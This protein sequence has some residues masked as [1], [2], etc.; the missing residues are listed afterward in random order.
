MTANDRM[1]DQLRNL[2]GQKAK[3][4]CIRLWFEL[5]LAGRDIWSDHGLDR[6]AQL[7]ALKWLNE[8]QHRVWGAHARDDD[9]AIS[10]LLACIVSHCEQSP[11]LGGHVRI[12][13]DSALNSV[14]HS[15]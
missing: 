11:I 2:R 9:E 12:A 10:G 14:A 8:I 6:D 7:N 1:R 4:F 13:L 3:D 5:T 15:K